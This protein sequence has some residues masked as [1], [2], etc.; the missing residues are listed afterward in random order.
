MLNYVE[1][2][3]TALKLTETAK[4]LG[5]KITLDK[6]TLPI[7]TLPIV[8]AVDAAT[9]RIYPGPVALKTERPDEI[10]V[11]ILSGPQ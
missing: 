2:K 11:N 7:A 3:N 6:G 4:L 9:I 8:N 5:I 1:A 10:F